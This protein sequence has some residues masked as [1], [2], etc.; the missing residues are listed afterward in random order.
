MQHAHQ[1]FEGGDLIAERMIAALFEIA[2]EH[3]NEEAEKEQRGPQKYRQHRLCRKICEQ[4]FAGIENHGKAINAGNE[5]ECLQEPAEVEFDHISRRERSAWR[6]E[7][8]V[9]TIRH[10]LCTLLCQCPW[11]SKYFS[12]SIAAWQPMPAAVMAWR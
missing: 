6:R 4:R 10:A 11:A 12:T 3:Q 5:S 9:I 2:R 7:H 1:R 8:N